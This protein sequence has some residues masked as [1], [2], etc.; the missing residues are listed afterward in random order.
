MGMGCIPV[1]LKRGGLPDIVR[2]GLTGFLAKDLIEI[3]QYT[4]QV[5]QMEPSLTAMLRR[6]A[7]ADVARFYDASFTA[8]FM[9]LVHRGRLT[10]PLRHLIVQSSGE[11]RGSAGGSGCGRLSSG[12]WA[13]EAP[14]Q[15]WAPIHAAS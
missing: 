1:V 4:L 6:K 13:P 10:K 12:P 15:G 5:V 14:S 9:T 11:V 3:K 2:H 8:K 7:A